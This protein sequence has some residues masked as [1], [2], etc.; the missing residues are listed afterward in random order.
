V[1]GSSWG[2]SWLFSLGTVFFGPEWESLRRGSNHL[3]VYVA[4]VTNKGVCASNVADRG[5]GLLKDLEASRI[6][7]GLVRLGL[8][9]GL[10]GRVGGL[11]EDGFAGVDFDAV[12]GD[13]VGS[14]L[15]VASGFAHLHD[16][17]DAGEGGADAHVLHD[18][19]AVGE[20]FFGLEAAFEAGGFEFAGDE[21][22][23]AGVGE[24]AD[25]VEGGDAF[26]VDVL[27]LEGEGGEG[28]DG[29]AG[30]VDAF[31]GGFDGLHEGGG[32]E[33]FAVDGEVADFEAAGDEAE[34]GGV[35]EGEFAVLF[36]GFEVPAEEVHFA[37]E[38]GFGFF[39]ADEDAVVVVFGD[40]LDEVLDGEDGFSGAG[41]A[42]GEDDAAWGEAA[43]DE[44]VE[45]VDSG[46]DAL[47]VL[48]G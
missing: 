5:L 36:V 44:F 31:G 16:L 45:A 22:G 12:V 28:V 29:D 32:G 19:D 24:G 34:G 38:V 10:G 30:G 14:G 18:D 4:G 26:L 21:G 11:F 35:D 17:E 3:V 42:G 46:G 23:G 41:F 8:T 15:V 33:V 25:E 20:E 2:T 39:H 48:Q 37:V 13:S 47:A 1:H 9:V 43:V 6:P 27:V 7:A 40:A